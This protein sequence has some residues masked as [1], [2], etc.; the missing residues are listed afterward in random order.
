MR[1]GYFA[2]C[3]PRPHWL[4]Q[5]D[6]QRE[7]LAIAFDRLLESG[8]PDL[9]QKCWGD[10]SETLTDYL[11]LDRCL[12]LIETWSAEMASPGQKSL[13]LQRGGAVFAHVLDGWHGRHEGVE[14]L[15]QL[16]RWR[17][18]LLERSSPE[19]RAFLE[20]MGAL[21]LDRIELERVDSW[22]E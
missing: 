21:T 12:R 6:N 17:Q 2:G 15:L 22:D 14:G 7:T 3:K 8:D 16:H 9:F 1:Y 5:E 11:S 13:L 20:R 19:V 18:S 10:S 4:Q